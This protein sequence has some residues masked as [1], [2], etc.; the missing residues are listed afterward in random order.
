MTEEWMLERVNVRKLFF[1]SILLLTLALGVGI[2]TVVTHQASADHQPVAERLKVQGEGS[3]LSIGQ[4]VDPLEGFSA[5]AEA[6]RPA[7]VNISTKTKMNVRRMHEDMGPFGDDFWRRF[8]GEDMPRNFVQ[9]SLGSG[10]IVDSKGFI[11]TNNHVVDGAD[12]ITVKLADGRE[13]D[14]T[15][16]GTDPAGEEGGSDL[17]VIRIKDS[18]PLPFVRLGDVENLKI[19][20]WL[21]A[22]G[23]PFGLEQSVTAGILSAKGRIFLSQSV[24]SSF[25]QTDAAINP[26]NSGGPLVNMRGEVVGI[27]TFIETRTGGNLGI[28]FAVPAD[29][30][31]NV[32]NQIVEFGKVSRGHMGIYMNTYPIT[33]AMEKYFGLKDKAGVIVTDLAEKE[34]PARDAGIQPEDV[35]VAF[36]GK[37]VADADALRSLVANTSPGSTI[38]VKVVRKGKE[39]TFQVKLGERPSFAARSTSGPLDL[40]EEAQNPKPEIGLT[41]EDIPA[42]IASQLDLKEGDGVLVSEV[43]SGSLAEDAHLAVNDII[44]MVDGQKVGSAQAF[45][46][47]IRGLKSGDSVVI[48]Y[49]RMA[50]RQKLVYYTSLTKP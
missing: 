2:G 20:E 27:N 13:F 34:S 11:V 39:M 44:V 8:F 47:K 36:N 46:D 10:I 29:V 40:D 9:R 21:V 5:V 4:K 22:I 18:K 28:G 3:P 37:E 14:A 30:V 41:V 23:S 43:K 42:R 35:I 19:G 15:V 16:V 26:G 25:L 24:F 38:P 48:K 6:V 49:F 32:Y 7:V 33:E 1:F 50:E 45:V 31:V 17:A 12:S